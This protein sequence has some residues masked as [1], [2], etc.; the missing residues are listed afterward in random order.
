MLSIRNSL[1]IY[2]YWQVESKRLGKIYHTNMIQ[3]KA[4]VAILISSK[5]DFRE[6]KIARDRVA[7]YIMVK[8]VNPP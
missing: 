3:G 8:G 1:Q 7:H 4:G 2:Q 5:I 6:K